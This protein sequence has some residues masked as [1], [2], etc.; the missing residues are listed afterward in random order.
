MKTASVNEVKSTFDAVLKASEE[1]PVVIT[2]RGKAV[3]V[4]IRVEDDDEAERL[5]MAYSPQLQAILDRSKRQIREGKGIPH[6][7]FWAQVEAMT[8]GNEKEE[9]DRPRRKR[10]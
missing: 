1:S 3:A 4:L 8:A 5:L 6:D 9:K 10:A 2:R 7:E